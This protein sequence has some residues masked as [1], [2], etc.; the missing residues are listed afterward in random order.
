MQK[1]KHTYENGKAF[2]NQRHT[3]FLTFM[4]HLSQKITIFFKN[5]F[6][7]V[8]DGVLCKHFCGKF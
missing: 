4:Y 7:I 6:Q 1:K 2:K 8:L 5:Q 3:E